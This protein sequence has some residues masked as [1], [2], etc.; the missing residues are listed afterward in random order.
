MGVT[1]FPDEEFEESFQKIQRGEPIDRTEVYKVLSETYRFDPMPE[2]MNFFVTKLGLDKEREPINWDE[3]KKALHEIREEVGAVA[4]N[5]QH[6]TSYN[7]LIADRFKHRRRKFGPME[8][9]KHAFSVNQE[10]GWHEEEVV[11][12]R[13]TKKSCAET[14]YADS[15]IKSGVDVY[16]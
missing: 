8:M 2:E 7:E 12:S 10:I 3:F 11:N 16:Y 6:Y 14:K 1:N 13:R 5:A 4:K 9:Y 15:L